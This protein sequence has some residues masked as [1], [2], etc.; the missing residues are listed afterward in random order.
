MCAHHQKKPGADLLTAD[1]NGGPAPSRIEISFPR[2]GDVFKLDPVLRREHQRIKLRVAVPPA[3][4]VTGIEWRVNGERVGDCGPPFSIFW[5]LR[6]GS[7][8]IKATAITAGPSLDSPPVKI[9]VLT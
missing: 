7:Y 6:P 5:N 4:G 2:D 8:T 9:L 3:E 1:K